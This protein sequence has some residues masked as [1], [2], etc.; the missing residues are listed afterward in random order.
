MK[1]SERFTKREDEFTV[2][3]CSNGYYVELKGRDSNDDWIN[4]RYI[5]SKF[6]ELV[7]SIL[8]FEALQR[9]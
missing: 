1:I 2:T 3:I 4:E 5:C 6:D 9:A 7:D 8:E